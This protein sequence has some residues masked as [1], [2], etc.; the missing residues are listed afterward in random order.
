MVV[1]VA[2]MR[3]I[4]PVEEVLGLVEAV[5]VV[6]VASLVGNP[7]IG[8]VTGPGATN[9]TLLA[10]WNASDAMLQGTLEASL[11]IPLK[12]PKFRYCTTL[13]EENHRLRPS[14]Y[15]VLSPF[16]PY[17][18][19]FFFCLFDYFTLSFFSLKLGSNRY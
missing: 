16:W 9:T 1:V 3:V 6:E 10:G 8:S 18:I 15:E 11:H 12:F 7:V 4:S 2:I 14:P 19:F 5:V 13:R 17:P